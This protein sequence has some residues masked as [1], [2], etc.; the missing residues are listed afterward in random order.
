MNFQKLK[1]EHTFSKIY[2]LSKTKYIFFLVLKKQKEKKTK[3][4][5]PYSWKLPLTFW[6]FIRSFSFVFRQNVRFEFRFLIKSI[7]AYKTGMTC[8]FF[9][10]D[11]LLESKFWNNLLLFAFFVVGCLHFWLRG[12]WITWYIYGVKEYRKG[13]AFL[14]FLLVLFLKDCKIIIALKKKEYGKSRKL[15]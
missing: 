6:T 4:F 9:C 14:I 15:I 5:A 8:W 2:K 1:S 11:F 13:K 3:D 7:N 10:F 12:T